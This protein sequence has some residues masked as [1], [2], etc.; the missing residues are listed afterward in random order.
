M[1]NVAV[2][3]NCIIATGKFVFRVQ[4]MELGGVKGEIILDYESSSKTC[5]EEWNS[6]QIRD[7]VTKL[8]FIEKNEEVGDK[9]VEG[10]EVGDRIKKF[11]HLSQVDLAGR[12]V[13]TLMQVYA[14]CF[15][16]LGYLKGSQSMQRDLG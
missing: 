14:C 2:E 1:K 11:L 3:L 4:R 7:F 10:E 15:D 9:K 8:G 13:V 12:L 6:G 16:V 5:R